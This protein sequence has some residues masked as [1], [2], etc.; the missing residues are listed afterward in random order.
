M[1]FKSCTQPWF[2]MQLR[3][4]STHSFCCFH[5]D[6]PFDNAKL[7][8]PQLW[9][10]PVFIKTR[11]EILSNEPKGTRC[12]GCPFIAY[13]DTPIF[14]EIP[15]YIKGARRE[16]WQQAINHYRAGDVKVQSLPIKYF[17]FFGL[18]CNLRCK[19]CD[20]PT[21]F[22]AG[23]KAFFDPTGLLED[24]RI[25]ASASMVDIIGGEPFLIPQAVKFID[26]LI[27]RPDTKDMQVAV[28]TNGMLLDRFIERFTPLDHVTMVV[29]LDSHGKYF[30]EI[31]QRSSWARIENNMRN[32][33]AH[34]KNHGKNWRTNIAVT[35]MKEG[36]LGYPDLVQYAIDL[37]Q[38]IHFAPVA[39]H[40]TDAHKQNIFANARLLADVPGWEK[41]MEKAIKLLEDDKRLSA[42]NQL[43]Q[44]Y[45]EF[46]HNFHNQSDEKPEKMIMLQ[47][48]AGI[49]AWEPLVRGQEMDFITQLGFNIYNGTPQ[50]AVRRKGNHIEFLPTN[51]RDHLATEFKKIG[52][53]DAGE[54]YVRLAVI[55]PD[56]A[57]PED[58]CD[59]EIQDQAFNIVP[60]A[61]A[62]DRKKG[63]EKLTYYKL[64]GGADNIRL[65]IRG[66]SHKPNALP[67]AV[68][69]DGYE[70]MV[71]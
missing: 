17:L 52:T 66:S 59:I 36:L 13:Y 55:W 16:N 51:P 50:E 71:S 53:G 30:E 20:H 32:F 1:E 27:A 6:L 57:S 67:L 56:D 64:E 3:Y 5:Y 46:L 38:S 31:R 70:G 58:F 23:E 14:L 40:T 37:G 29:S 12:E 24:P 43:R 42:A 49:N 41:A 10:G 62:I 8:V 34:G 35:V 68:L 69:L 19:M 47:K 26:T 48:M 21:R 7:D 54:K 9:N 4:N 39:S 65:L 2:E 25:M 11:S 15:D 61:A 22:N 33:L 60:Y 18:A 45:N 63:R 44:M 28:Y